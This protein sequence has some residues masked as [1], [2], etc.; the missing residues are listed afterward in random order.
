M[1][2]IF[3]RTICIIITA[4][5]C[6]CV[7]ACGNTTKKGDL[8]DTALYLEDTE[9]GKGDKELCVKVEAGDKTVTFIIHTDAETVGEALSEHKL[10]SGE[11]GPYGMYVKTVNGITADYDI[12]Q[13]Y[14]SFNKNGEYMQTG[15]DATSFADGDSY[16][17]VYTK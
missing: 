17:L 5:L 6:L 13:S 1:R 11:K 7:S 10:I 3:K 9:L 2:K 16:E 12:D 4:V 14:W 8:W 15:V